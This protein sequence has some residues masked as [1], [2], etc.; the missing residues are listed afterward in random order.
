MKIALI[1][2]THW[3]ARNDSLNFL[4]YFHT[5]YDDVFFPYLDKNNIKNVVHLGDVVDRR[6]FINY[7]ILRALKY[8]FVDELK[9]RDIDFRVLIGNHDVVY[10]NTNEVN[11]M[12]EIFG[13]D[14]F[15]KSYERAE[16]IKFDGCDVLLVPWI[17]R[18][19]YDHSMKAIQETAAQV[20]FGHLEV[21][22]HLMM[23]GVYCD[24]GISQSLFK[25]FEMVFSGHF[26]HRNTIGN[27]TYLGCPY[28]MNWSDYNHKKGFHIFDTD[29]RALTFIPNPHKMYYKFWYDDEGKDDAPTIDTSEFKGSYIKVIV[30]SKTNPYWFDMLMDRIYKA[31][32]EHVQVVD[33]HKNLDKVTEEDIID[34]A[35]DTLTILNKYID[36]IPS[37][38]VDKAEK[39]R[40]SVL[41]H[42]LY[43]E[44]VHMEA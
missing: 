15:V 6:K 38:E 4:E 41:L 7:N 23:P 28:E 19:N 8:R 1:T 27:V 33:D 24:H 14:S 37:K 40:L 22:G 5:F 11:A 29:T 36:S 35:E 43:T 18:E 31:D 3:G 32:P 25:R 13:D 9:K 39:A 42:G 26:H 30:Q 16:T 12:H 10:R 2:D 17:N 21:N 44:A 34:E 20:C